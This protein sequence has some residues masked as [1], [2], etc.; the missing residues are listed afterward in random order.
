MLIKPPRLW[1]KTTKLTNF[2]NYTLLSLDTDQRPAVFI[3]TN[4]AGKTNLIE[5]VSLL[6]P[7]RGLR[8]S[9]YSDL[10]RCGGTG[11]WAVA[12]TLYVNDEKTTIGTGVQPGNTAH[13]RSG[14]IVRINGTSQSGTGILANHTEMIWLTPASD[15]MF[16]GPVSERR[17][18]IDRLI[19]CFDP[20]HSTRT[21][22]FERAMR[23]RN[24]LL[25][26][27]GSSSQLSGLETIMA[28]TGVAISAARL[29]AVLSL[30]A[31]MHIRQQ[32]RS[33][34]LFPLA[35][36][37]LEG[38]LECALKNNPAIKVEDW[39]RNQLTISRESDRAAGRTL[40]GPHRSDLIVSDGL[41]GMLAR[42]CSTGEQKTLLISIVLAH[43]ELVSE[44]RNGIAP[45]LLLD[46]IAA[47]LDN[48]HRAALFDD[49]LRIGTQAWMTGTDYI[50]FSHLENRA[51][52]FEVE[53]GHIKRL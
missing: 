4:G 29:E 36:L 44:R 47:H 27:D 22:Q 49:I 23:Q 31:T 40:V 34:T 37:D 5:A 50:A 10:A 21:L 16:T 1:I 38:D 20:D 8:R 41:K 19:L 18:F 33:D 35:K 2:R 52:F 17:R 15:A 3:G 14:R 25:H 7:G 39:Y 11:D 32:K 6:S 53:N 46:E 26:H 30:R 24:R 12:A 43:A 51:Q 28:E 48:M 9:A 45:I 13:K 42:N